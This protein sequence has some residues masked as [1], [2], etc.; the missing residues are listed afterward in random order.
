MLGLTCPLFKNQEEY[1]AL[2]YGVDPDDV[3]GYR[4][5]YTGD[6]ESIPINIARVLEI[7]LGE[8]SSI[9]NRYRLFR[10]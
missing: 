8:V 7:E 2:P 4:R 5:N 6:P 3:L 1:I 10:G 9:T